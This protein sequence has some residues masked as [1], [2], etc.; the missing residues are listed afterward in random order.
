MNAINYVTKNG[1]LIDLDAA[2]MLMDDELC[3]L[4]H[5]TVETDQKFFDFYIAAH[6]EKFG[7]DFVLS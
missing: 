1:K 6:Q 2:R 5:G 3:N 7:E 4:I